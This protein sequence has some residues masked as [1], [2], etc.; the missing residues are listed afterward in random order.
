MARQESDR[1]DLFAEVTGLVRRLQLREGETPIVAGFRRSGGLTIYFGPDL[2]AGFNAEL[3]W[4]RG[5][6]DGVL[7]RTGAGGTMQ[8]LRR[9]R[10]AARSVLASRDLSAEETAAFLERLRERL[11]R[12]AMLL[13]QESAAVEAAHPPAEADAV[14]TEVWSAVH[15]LSG[16][17]IR[18]ADR[19]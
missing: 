14:R 7:Y 8:A 19:L 6:C 9:V 16:Q 18:I 1:E 4:R 11:K 13:E 10:S 17:P 2:V 3:Q 12:L 15:R 5:Y